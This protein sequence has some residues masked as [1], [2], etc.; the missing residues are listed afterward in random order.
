ML[1]L[2]LQLL[3]S[4]LLVPLCRCGCCCCCCCHSRCCCFGC[5]VSFSTCTPCLHP[6]YGKT[7]F[8]VKTNWCCSFQYFLTNHFATT[9]V[10]YIMHFCVYCLL[11]IKFVPYEKIIFLTMC[12]C[13]LNR[14]VRGYR[15]IISYHNPIV[16]DLIYH[17]FTGEMRA[18]R[19]T[20]LTGVSF[21]E[22]AIC[23]SFTSGKFQIV[24]YWPTRYSHD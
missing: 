16:S 20:N 24:H 7:V 4:L 17:K 5:L 15:D 14:A 21:L 3:L 23:V 9:F 19:K 8:S 12:S 10:K 22:A 2:F 18:C 11:R 6:N 13:I 1:L